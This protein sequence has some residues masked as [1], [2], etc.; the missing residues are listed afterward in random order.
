M[1]SLLVYVHFPYCLKK[2]PYC[3]FASYPATADRIDH[4]RYADAIIAELG[5]RAGS[6]PADAELASVFFGGG[7]PSL[8]EPKEL[9]RALKAIRAA[10]PRE[11]GDLEVTVE[12]NPSSFDERRASAMLDQGVNRVSIG[13]QSLDS[14]RLAFL[15]RLHD[16]DGGLEAL[17]AAMRA[18][19]TRVSG[20]LIF[21]VQGGRPQTS[22][23]ASCEVDRVAETGVRHLSA[24]GLTIESGTQFGELHRKGR[25]PVAT[26]DVVVDSFFAI[27]EALTARGFSHYEISNYAVPGEEARHNLGYWRGADYLGLGCAAVGT[28]SRA[29]GTALRHKN[30]PD[31]GRYMKG[32]FAGAPTLAEE[33]VLSAEMRLQERIMLGLRLERGLDLAEAGRAL[34][35]DPFTPERRAAIDR[36]AA[37]NRLL[38]EGSHLRVAPQARAL[39]D[40]IVAALF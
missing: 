40:G 14:E 30:H 13:I 7:T 38:V 31:P 15:G 29:D 2:C 39:T 1:R 28:M 27:E 32:V 26:D 21:G 20:D 6:I 19:F 5:L 12:C 4:V 9:G 25:L 24:Y 22:Q 36:L 17:R 10:V 33:E 37:S 16:A 3:D 8:W 23:A 11:R 18:G 35:V 34:G